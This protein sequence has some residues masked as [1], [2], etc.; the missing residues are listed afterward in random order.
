[1]KRLVTLLLVIFTLLVLTGCS[2]NNN[3]SGAVPTHTEANLK[4][5]PLEIAGTIEGIEGSPGDSSG[6]KINDLKTQ[7][8]FK[9]CN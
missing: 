1:M 9:N 6:I 5:I 8:V 7:E 4:S 3:S 2:S